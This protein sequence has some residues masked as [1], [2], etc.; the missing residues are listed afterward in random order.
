[1]VLGDES[2]GTVIEAGSELEDRFRPGEVYV[3]QPDLGDGRAFGYGIPGGLVRYRTVPE[4]F[5][6]QL[7]RVEKEA[8]ERYGFFSFP[9][10]EPLGCVEK[11]CTIDFRPAPRRGGRMLLVSSFGAGKVG[12]GFEGDDGVPEGGIIVDPAGAFKEVSEVLVSRGAELR[13]SDTADEGELFDDIVLAAGDDRE[14]PELFENVGRFLDRKGTLSVIADGVEGRALPVDVG[15]V[16]YE[17]HIVLGGSGP[18]ICSCYRARRGYSPF[19]G[20]TVLLLGAGGPMGQMFVLWLLG[21]DTARP[22]RVVCTDVDDRRLEALRRLG[23]GA[24]SGLRFDVVD[25]RGASPSDF[26][27][28]GEVDYLVILC[29]VL[30][31]VTGCLPFLA[32]G[33]VIN[34][35]AGMKG[36]TLPL[37]IGTVASRRLRIVGFSGLDTAAMR[38]A[39]SR[40][41][42]GKVDV[43]PVVA[44]VGGFDTGGEAL[45]AC[46][47]GRYPGKIVVYSGVDAPLRPFEDITGGESWSAEH[48]RRFLEDNS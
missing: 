15:A 37:D 39:L 43:S 11:S 40:I 23:G 22:E 19:Q 34:C 13:P 31:A 36:A 10:A 48:E 24:P 18:D 20:D 9:L 3:I 25:A 2:I 8:V 38:S 41:V 32:D 14:L 42:E 28:E 5:C 44:A 4:E 47:A 27:S 30:E 16:H 7:L 1:V 45:E 29:P 26:L 12:W 6:G 35:F 21:N 17:G 33:A 46:G